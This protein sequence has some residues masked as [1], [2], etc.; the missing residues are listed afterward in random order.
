ML[1]AAAA[2][3]AA[4]LGVVYFGARLGRERTLPR[5]RALLLATV[6]YL[7]AVLCVMVVDRRV[8]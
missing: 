4:G 7:P 1:H 6:I 5:A 3:I 2:A 8:L